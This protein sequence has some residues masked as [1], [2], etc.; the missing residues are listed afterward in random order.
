MRRLADDVAVR[1][2]G[3]QRTPFAASRW[4]AGW[5][6][7]EFRENGVGHDADHRSLRAAT[8]KLLG[9]PVYA[10]RVGR[11]T[12]PRQ[13]RFAQNAFE[14]RV[15]GLDEFG[16]IPR[17]WC[18]VT[19]ATAAH[20]HCRS[21]APRYRPTL[22]MVTST[23]LC[24][25]LKFRCAVLS[26]TELVEAMVVPV[27]VLREAGA[28]RPCPGADLGRERR[29]HDALVVRLAGVHIGLQ[30]SDVGAFRVVAQ[31]VVDT[32]FD[33]DSMA[34]LHAPRLA[35][36]RIDGKNGLA[37]PSH[38]CVLGLRGPRP[39]AVEPPA[40]R[41]QVPALGPR[42]FVEHVEDEVVA[43]EALRVLHLQQVHARA[44]RQ[45]VEPD[46]DNVVAAI[47]QPAGLAT[48]AASHAS[49]R[50]PARRHPPGCARHGCEWAC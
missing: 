40:A 38:R 31:R 16:V 29:P 3:G 25:R 30:V 5:P 20:R 34:K 4:S 17:R 50:S 42:S 9:G 2:R 6:G 8:G 33:R 44:R 21:H 43:V 28:R 27:P 48:H 35:G 23:S 11:R 13:Q 19:S 45:L 24:A 18:R 37:I 47:R 36:R 12:E 39:L 1:E 41:D 10:Q 22:S 7:D 46:H 32:L 15:A 49:D 14:D 26:V